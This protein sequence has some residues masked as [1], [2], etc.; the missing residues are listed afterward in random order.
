MHTGLD[1]RPGPCARPNQISFI[2][3]FIHLI[4][5][6]LKLRLVGCALF[7]LPVFPAH[8]SSATNLMLFNLGWARTVFLSAVEL[9]HLIVCLFTFSKESG[10]GPSQL[11]RS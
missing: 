8:R 1:A 11:F 9:G 2:D 10:S 3:S 7:L 6:G 4:K 5:R